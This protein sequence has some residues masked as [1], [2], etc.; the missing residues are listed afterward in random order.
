MYRFVRTSLTTIGLTSIALA[1]LAGGRAQSADTDL[2]PALQQI[3]DEVR[4]L[5]H[6]VKALRELLEKKSPPAVP[7]QSVEKQPGISALAGDGVYYLYSRTDALSP[8]MTFMIDHLKGQGYSI[9]KIEV[10]ENLRHEYGVDLDPI[11]FQPLLILKRGGESQ[12]LRGLQ[13]EDTLRSKVA[14]YFGKQTTSQEKPSSAN[15]PGLHEPPLEAWFFYAKW[16]GP[17]QQMLPLIDKL[18]AE[19][20]RV[21]KVDID[22]DKELATRFNV[23]VVP[24]LW[25]AVFEPQSLPL[26]G[27]QTEE[28]IRAELN[29]RAVHGPSG[30]GFLGDRSGAAATLPDR[31]VIQIKNYI[32]SFAG[33]GGKKMTGN[34]MIASVDGQPV[35]ASEIFQRAG[36]RALTPDGTSLM[37]ATKALAAGQIDEPSFRQL[38]LLAL[39]K[40]SQDHLNTRGWAQ[41]MIASLGKAEREKAENAITDEF[42]KY[43][44]KLKQDFKVATAFDV[45]KKLR[46]QGTS[47]LALKAEFRDR[48]LA[49]EFVRGATKRIAEPPDKRS[50]AQAAGIDLDRRVTIDGDERPLSEVL[51]K[52][53]RDEP[54]INFS[55]DQALGTF[56]YPIVHPIVRYL[57]AVQNEMKSVRRLVTV[58]E[59]LDEKCPKR[60]TLHVKDVS[61]AVALQR[62]FDQT[63][64]D[65]W[66]ENGVLRV[67]FPA[68]KRLHQALQRKVTFDCDKLPLRKF[69]RHLENDWQ[70]GEVDISVGVDREAPIT[71]HAADATLEAVLKLGCQQAHVRWEFQNGRLFLSPGVDTT[72]EDRRIGELIARRQ[73]DP[74]GKLITQIVVEGN[75]TISASAIL[76]KLKVTTGRKASIQ[77]IQDDVRTLWLTGWFNTIEVKFRQPQ[78]GP[79]QVLVFVVAERPNIRNAQ[80]KADPS[81]KA[82]PMVG[83]PDDRPTYAYFFYSK[84]SPPCQQ[85]LPIIDRL[86][87]EGH[88]IIKVDVDAPM[89]GEQTRFKVKAVPTLWINAGDQGIP[90]S[91][92]Q[93]EEE[94]RQALKHFGD[95]RPAEPARKRPESHAVVPQL[96]R[97][98]TIDCDNLP[99][100]EVLEQIFR[101]RPKIEFRYEQPFSTFHYPY[102]HFP[103]SE[104]DAKRSAQKL[105]EAHEAA[106]LDARCPQHV[107]LHVADVPVSVA[108]QRIFDQLHL[109]Y[110]FENGSLRIE[111]PADKKLREAL[112]RRMN[113]D[114]EKLSLRQ[115]IDHMWKD[116]HLGNVVVSM[117]VNLQAPITMHVKEVTLESVLKQG[118]Q[119]AGVRCEFQDEMF[120]LAPADPLVF[121]AYPVA[122]LLLAS[123]P[124]SGAVRDEKIDF[125]SL[126]KLIRTAAEPKSWEGAGGEGRIQHVDK[127]LSLVIGQTQPVHEQIQ[128]LLQELRKPQGLKI[129][130]RTILLQQHAAEL[131]DAAGIN[132]PAEHGGSATLLA[133][134]RCDFLVRLAT[135]A[136]R[137]SPLAAVAA[138]VGKEMLVHPFPGKHVWPESI[139]AISGQIG[140]RAYIW[141]ELTGNDPTTGQPHREGVM[142]LAPEFKPVLVRLKRAP[143]AYHEPAFWGP[144]HTVDQVIGKPPE[145]RFLLIKPV[146]EFTDPTKE[147][148]REETERRN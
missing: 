67:D 126:E 15:E 104:S 48:L 16:S 115:F 111:F 39:R 142:S 17:S 145:P 53:F 49:D 133:K 43:V 138:D 96:D 108:L 22:T 34:E 44:E 99:L 21:A 60:I 66:I 143:E 131:I 144:S 90:L 113:F 101:E 81:A 72:E 94:I 36:T 24:T 119:Q 148:P 80:G 69:I 139:Q 42:N 57:P 58:A 141:F 147:G 125:N 61:V 86:Q 105:L 76:K 137:L 98:V 30:T 92:I 78:E 85:M 114:C 33:D 64:L 71:L 130:L 56:H 127:T 132:A 89:T 93:T 124:Q 19:G 31:K 47:L 46:E 5:R 135:D 140:S 38:Q 8:L 73:A 83:H 25:L 27:V 65:Y 13:P 2:Q 107:R 121:L 103:G 7:A 110:E 10:A 23:T 14:A 12:V 55:Y 20:H 75:S 29:K 134:D 1:A 91:G 97:H 11:S 129:T 102:F 122:D 82:S 18:R 52:I 84:N 118:F 62:V 51:D 37:T 68:D 9:K 41:A 120:L 106:N 79:G 32:E 40:F 87:A 6:D 88:R 123:Q 95:W 63:P 59:Y 116:W 117:T 112:Q 70:L 45:D 128:H 136:S 35:F 3:R 28:T 146:I 50:Q 54:I 4:D 77:A 109:R 74:E 26:Q 100:S